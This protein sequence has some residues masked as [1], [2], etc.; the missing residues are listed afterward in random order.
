MSWDY[1]FTAQNMVKSIKKPKMTLNKL[2]TAT[3]GEFFSMGKK[4]EDIREN[5]A[6]KDDLK[7][8]ATKDDLRVTEVKILQAVDRVVTHSG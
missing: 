4:I 2:A 5:M 3:Q 6:A 8:F 1:R 7:R